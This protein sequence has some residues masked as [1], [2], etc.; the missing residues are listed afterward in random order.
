MMAIVFP[1]CLPQNREEA[2]LCLPYPTPPAGFCPTMPALPGRR[3][4][5]LPATC[6]PP[7]PFPTL[8]SPSSYSPCL[9]FCHTPFPSS[10]PSVLCRW[11]IHAQCQWP[12]P[13]PA[14]DS[15][16]LLPLYPTHPPDS[17]YTH[18]GWRMWPAPPV[19]PTTSLFRSHLQ[20][21]VASWPAFVDCPTCRVIFVH[22]PTPHLH[23][24]P[25]T[26]LPIL[27]PLTFCLDAV[28]A[29]RLYFPDSP[30]CFCTLS[31]A[32]LCLDRTVVLI[33][34]SVPGF[35]VH[36]TLHTC[37][38]PYLPTWDFYL[39]STYP[40]VLYLG[41]TFFYHLPFLPLLIPNLLPPPYGMCRLPSFCLGL[42]GYIPTSS[43]PFPCLLSAIAHTVWVPPCSP[44]P[45]PMCLTPS[46]LY[47]SPLG[48]SSPAFMGW[49]R[50][51]FC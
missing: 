25:Y 29:F 23:H 19:Y 20:P 24:S 39:I 4:E 17:T 41:S 18:R 46:P 7:C 8:F 6:L 38:L 21:F 36:Y 10:L 40:F 32:T 27:V 37:C 22:L 43:I 42:C 30:P 31:H 11:G 16:H 9:P 5:D 51:C 49:D 33:S 28:P 47:H 13:I 2:F 50:R 1:F 14:A 44:C 3:R 12:H 48:S 35:C 45:H 26:H 34:S 15:C